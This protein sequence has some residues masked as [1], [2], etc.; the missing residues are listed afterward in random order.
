MLRWGMSNIANDYRSKSETFIQAALLESDL[1]ERG[2]FL[3]KAIYW[4]QKAMQAIGI[5]KLARIR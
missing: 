1:V 3:G 5:R 4:N 2:G